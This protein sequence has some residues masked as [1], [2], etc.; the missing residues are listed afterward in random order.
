MTDPFINSA[1]LYF[2]PDVPPRVPI[3]LLTRAIGFFASQGITLDYFDVSET[4]VFSSDETY[5]FADHKG[6][7]IEAV[8]ES[9]VARVGLYF[10]PNPEE[11]RSAW[12]AM[13]AVDMAMGMVFVGIDEKRLSQPG[14]LLRL[15][16]H[17]GGPALGVRY[18]IGYKQARSRG[19]ECYAAGV[20]CG[21]LANIKKW[22]TSDDEEMKRLTAWRN[23]KYGTRRYLTGLFRGAYPASLISREHLAALER[24][25]QGGHVLGT[26]TPVVE[27][28][29]W[30]WELTDSKIS[31]AAALLRD[32]ALLVGE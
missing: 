28:N 14:V 15:A 13:V 23:E 29:V 10:N 16:Y 2:R 7:L 3:L 30:I 21:S 8:N 25:A 6:G 24:H 27:N 22:L 1:A 12:Q 26:I 18:A 19:P 20:Q 9:R 31:A 17:I 11:A 32:N 5:Y 4:D